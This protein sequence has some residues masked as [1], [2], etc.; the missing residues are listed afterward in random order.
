MLYYN[1]SKGQN[2]KRKEAKN[3]TTANRMGVHH[4]KTGGNR[5]RQKRNTSQQTASD[6]DFEKTKRNANRLKRG[7]LRP[8]PFPV[9]L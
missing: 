1:Q 2:K 5:K 7:G 3:E 8:F 6:R 9:K 4:L